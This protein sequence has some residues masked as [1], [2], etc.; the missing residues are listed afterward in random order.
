M[1][2][3]IYSKDYQ[4]FIRKLREARLSAGLTQVDV[5]QKLKKPQSYVSK[6]ERGDRRVD[7]AELKELARHYKKSLDYF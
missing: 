3:S 6:I 1:P 4:A 5:A 7:I 2:R